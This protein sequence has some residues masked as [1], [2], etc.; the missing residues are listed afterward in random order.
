M[1]EAMV[2]RYYVLGEVPD[3]FENDLS[4]IGEEKE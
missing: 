3:M 4:L 1:L 2:R